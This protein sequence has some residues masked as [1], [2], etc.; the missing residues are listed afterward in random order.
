VD[1]QFVSFELV[2]KKVIN[3]ICTKLQL[4]KSTIVPIFKEDENEEYL[5][6]LNVEKLR[7]QVIKEQERL[8]KG[9]R[10]KKMRKYLK[11]KKIKED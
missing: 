7:D 11:W 3:D 6:N 2:D 1:K 9:I 4:P 8:E 5:K 10:E